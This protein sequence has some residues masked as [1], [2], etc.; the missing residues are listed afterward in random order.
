MIKHIAI[1]DAFGDALAKLGAQNNKVVAL[2]ADVGSSS[3][4]IVFGKQFPERYFNVGISELDMVAMSAGFATSGLIPF[5]N[6]FAVFM[7]TRASDPIN[8]LISYDKLN[9]KLCGTYCGLSDSYDGA[10]HHSLTD[11]S[12]V[13]ALPNMTVISVCDAV[14]TEKAVFAAA[15]LDGPVYL[16]LSRAEAPVIFDESY[17]FEIGKGVT[18]QDGGDVTIIATGY[19][20]Q[21]SLEAAELLKAEGISAR[22][23][24]LHTIKPIDRELIVKCAKETGAIVTAEE[25]SIYGGLGSAVSEVIVSEHPVPM[26]FVGL[27]DFTESGDYEALLSKYQLDAA[28][29]A[30][31]AK[32]AIARK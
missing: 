13:R 11:L 10:S 29:I 28:A 3:K 16:R 9:V 21:K 12:F 22:V 25:H 20:V 15:A 17:Q 32:T 6:T 23:V 31:K 30:A 7:T 14:E 4:S 19:M 24:D 5:V 8:S 1:R 27:T 18:L 2:E 26:E